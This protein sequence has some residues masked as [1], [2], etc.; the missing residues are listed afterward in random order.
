MVSMLF[1]AAACGTVT[2]LLI[3][4]LILL[5]M[6]TR[7]QRM[8]SRTKRRRPKK[9]PTADVCSICFGVFS[10]GDTIAKCKCGEMFHDACAQ[11][12]EKCPYCG[13]PYDEFT[14]DVPEYVQ[15]PACGNDVVGDVCTCGAVV[16]RDGVF[17]CSCGSPLDVNDPICRRC[18]TEYDVRTGGR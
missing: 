10:K 16:N 9:K 12:T 1:A 13:C 15:C 7:T 5:K 3:I 2:A 14:R 6:R 4:L 8:L 11:P 18:G 17:T